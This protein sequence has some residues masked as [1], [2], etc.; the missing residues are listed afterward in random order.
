LLDEAESRHDQLVG[1]VWQGYQKYLTRLR[2]LDFDDL[3]LETVRLLAE[4]D[5]IREH[6]AMRYKYILVDEYQDTNHPLFVVGM[7]EG[8][9]PHTRAVA[10]GSVEEERRLA[11]VG[12]TRAMDTLTMSWAF[13]RAKYG[14]RARSTPSRF[15]FEAEGETTPEGWAGVETIVQ[16][17]QEEE[18]GQGLEE[19]EKEE[20]RATG[21]QGCALGPSAYSSLPV[22]G[23]RFVLLFFAAFFRPVFFLPALGLG[24]GSELAVSRT[25]WQSCSWSS[26]QIP[27]ALEHGPVRYMLPH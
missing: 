20:V 13:E 9:L 10:E 8:I 19:E 7:E 23:R 22:R 6:Y 15:L 17:L 25:S 16:R 26:R 12:I 27:E 18:E 3:L 14:R 5:K 1:S 4:H 24:A 21:A 11:Y 2:T